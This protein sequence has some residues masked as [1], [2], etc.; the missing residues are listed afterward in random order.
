[1]DV[2]KVV[3]KTIKKITG[4]EGYLA[5]PTNT[6]CEFFTVTLTSGGGS[7]FMD[8]CS[9]DVDVWASDENSRARARSMAETII[10]AAYELDEIENIFSPK[11]TNVYY[12]PD[13]DT[14]RARYVVQV[15]C[16]IC[17]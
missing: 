9:L 8:E 2:E 3:T 6:P 7:R 15:E 14:R 10:A 1:M 17:E 4:I 11:V 16:N 13:A 5:V 12:S